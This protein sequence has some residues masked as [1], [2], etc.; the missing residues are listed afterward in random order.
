[1]KLMAGINTEVVVSTF[2]LAGME[3]GIDT[4]F[5]REAIFFSGEI[6][7][8]PTSLELFEGVINVRGNIVPILNMRKRL[9]LDEE[10]SAASKCIAIV[11]FRNRY[12]GL[13]FDNI[14]QV[15]RLDKAE[16]TKFESTEEDENNANQGIILIEQGE[17][18]LQV[19]DLELIFKNCNLPMVDNDSLE[20]TKQFLEI[21]QD[22]TFMVGSQEY[23][24]SML[25]IQE[26]IRVDEIKNKIEHSPFVRGVISLRGN[27]ISIVDLKKYLGGHKTQI[28]QDTRIIVFRDIPNCGILVDSVREVINYEVDKLL[29]ITNFD[30]TFLG[31]CF[32]NI[33]SISESRNIVK[34]DSV[35]LF[36]QEAQTQ[37]N[38]G[39][40]VNKDV[41]QS[42]SLKSDTTTASYI[43][44]KDYIVFKLDDKYAIDINNFQEIIKYSDH[45]I[46][47]PNSKEALKGVLNLRGEAVSVVDLRKYYGIANYSDINSC[48]ILILILNS[49][50]IGIIVD[51][52]LEILKTSKTK[53]RR[54]SQLAANKLM[55]SVKNHVQDLLVTKKETQDG[56]TSELLIVL[57]S[58]KIFSSFIEDEYSDSALIEVSAQECVEQGGETLIDDVEEIQAE[59]KAVDIAEEEQPEMWVDSLDDFYARIEKMQLQEDSEDKE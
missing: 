16:L 54:S 59:Q 57:D 38:D 21:K 50:K 22:I 10:V 48:K 5:V 12:F 1:M 20:T 15:V 24:L 58:E 40:I 30:K 41:C 6:V 18:L 23:S 56:V 52:V 11:S 14:S 51:D 45:I 26:I 7:K 37:I 25:E 3:F 49:Q 19:L 32:S 2:I 53:V 33:I 31:D 13:H 34:I 42:Q 36:S 43:E 44:D 28:S 55:D 47:L 39:L 46:N 9:G 27:L 35:T 17:K 4:K 8:I 29:P